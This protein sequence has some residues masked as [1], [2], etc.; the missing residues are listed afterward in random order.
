MTEEQ[1]KI[2]FERMQMMCSTFKLNSEKHV[3][4]LPEFKASESINGIL[5]QSDILT[6][7]N[8]HEILKILREIDLTKHYD[9]SQ[10]LD[11]KI[12][13]N[14]FLTHKGYHGEIF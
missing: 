4:F 14:A 2:Q 13:L 12:H 1:L 11:Y 9:G 8:Y 7:E 6:T 3:D 10:W 5:Q